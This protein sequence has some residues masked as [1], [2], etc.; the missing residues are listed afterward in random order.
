[1]KTNQNNNVTENSNEEAK[2]ATI[3]NQNSNSDFFTKKFILN[4]NNYKNLVVMATDKFYDVDT[5]NNNLIELTSN[6]L[7][8]LIDEAFT[9]YKQENLK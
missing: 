1:M 2:N 8:T 5:N 3:K 9:K 4:K 6:M 7:N